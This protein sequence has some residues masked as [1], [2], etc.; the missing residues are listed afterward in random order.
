MNRKKFI[1]IVLGILFV[2]ALGA[3]LYDIPSNIARKEIALQVAEDEAPK[4]RILETVNAKL[5]INNKLHNSVEISEYYKTVTIT[6]WFDDLDANTLNYAL[7]E[8]NILKM[9]NT[10]TQQLVDIDISIGESVASLGQGQY[11]VV[12]NLVNASDP[13]QVFATVK[14]G[15][16]VYDIVNATPPG[17]LIISGG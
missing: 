14:N 6:M 4:R 2:I 16:L 17:Q 5:E 13:S 8:N 3:A 11:S 9:W 1:C 15:A 10:V 7:Y 12:I